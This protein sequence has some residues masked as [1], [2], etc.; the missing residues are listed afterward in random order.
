M[1]H[2]QVGLAALMIGVAGRD[3]CV[4]CGGAAPLWRRQES[5]SAVGA[6]AATSGHAA[7]AADR[8][9]QRNSAADAGRS[10]S[11]TR[12]GAA[13]AARAVRGVAR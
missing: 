4:R 8:R 12:P 7:A 11:G 10:R 13:A 5:R 6:G 3:I 9:R 1:K 2:L